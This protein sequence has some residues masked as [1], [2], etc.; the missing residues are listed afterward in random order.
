MS[1]VFGEG[2]D[3]TDNTIVG[4]GNLFREEEVMFYVIDSSTGRLIQKGVDGQ[5]PDE[6]KEFG[7]NQADPYHA[8]TYQTLA[9][10]E[11]FV[12]MYNGTNNTFYCFS[13]MGFYL[14]EALR[15]KNTY[16]R[17]AGIVSYQGSVY[18]LLTSSSSSSTIVTLNV[19]SGSI[20]TIPY[21]EI[22][23]Y[24]TF[25]GFPLISDFAV[26]QLTGEFYVG[27]ASRGVYKV[28][29]NGNLDRVS[30]QASPQVSRIS[31]HNGFV[32]YMDT[33]KRV[34]VHNPANRE[35]QCYTTDTSNCDAEIAIGPLSFWD[36][37][38]KMGHVQ[39]I[40]SRTHT[41]ERMVSVLPAS[42][43]EL[44]PGTPLC[45]GNGK[46]DDFAR[47]NCGFGYAGA[48]CSLTCACP[49]QTCPGDGTCGGFGSCINGECI[50]EPGHY[51]ADCTGCQQPPFQGCFAHMT[52]PY[53]EPDEGKGVFEC[54]PEVTANKNIAC[55]LTQSG[56]IN[57]MCPDGW[58]MVGAGD[59]CTSVEHL[60]G[61]NEIRKKCT[62]KCA[63]NK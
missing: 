58:D 46:C 8:V 59:W 37:A 35:G 43:F 23:V 2:D 54:S 18:A 3:P 29:P 34:F 52:W 15:L 48:D 36:V 6:L 7:I 25:T 33:D 62:R 9:N 47:C 13:A 24:G 21:M 55:C 40:I 42:P 31:A 50:C 63:A 22:N 44:C 1:I 20:V 57:V 60:T 14:I 11:Q 16:E 39:L 10:M 45:S 30:K 26:D 51:G 5:N 12:W 32:Y 61:P 49:P 17:C 27:F 19:E 53:C 56:D 28:I 41:A 4:L 38:C